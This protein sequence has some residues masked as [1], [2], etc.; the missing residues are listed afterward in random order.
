MGPICCKDCD[1]TKCDGCNVYVLAMAL[2]EGK[3]DA[4]LNEHHSI[5]LNRLKNYND[6][7]KC[8]YI[9]HYIGI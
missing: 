4:L 1:D 9:S 5:D 6:C 3:L 7:S 8:I 2:S